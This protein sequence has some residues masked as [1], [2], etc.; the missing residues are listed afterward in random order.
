TIIRPLIYVSEKDIITFAKQ[1]EI[2]KTFCKCPMGQKSKR[3]DVK[4]IILNIEN[5]FPNIKSN[6]SKASFLYGSKKALLGK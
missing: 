4:K 2:L 6:L 3:N 5:N 1:N